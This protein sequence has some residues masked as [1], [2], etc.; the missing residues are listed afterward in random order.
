[1]SLVIVLILV[2]LWLLV[3]VPTGWRRFSER[4]SSVSIDS[5]HR[6]LHLLERTGP[7]L[8]EPAFR[9][10]TAHSHNG[11]APGQSGYPAVTSMPGRPQ[12]VLL[13]PAGDAETGA[14][15]RRL[16]LAG[17]PRHPLA[18]VPTLAPASW[19]PSMS[20]DRAA[21]VE[22]HRRRQ[23]YRRR[24]EI[25]LVLLAG[26]TLTGLLGTVHSLRALWVITF[27]CAIGLAGFV[28]LSAYAH[29][30]R[31][32]SAPGLGG[33][34]SGARAPGLGPERLDRR[35]QVVMAVDVRGTTVPYDFETMPH[36]GADDEDF[37][38]I[39]RWAVAR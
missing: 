16:P 25:V 38:D 11:L 19:T 12:L 24:R 5:F 30:L 7:K 17:G 6:E 13:P 8:V 37:E 31:A 29:S 14:D 35:Q 34:R 20:I 36:G 27:L 39:P 15:D 3:L 18:A 21:E 9:L 4:R 32:M 23:A 2:V 33:S 10:E 26:L 1:V 28:A 22:R